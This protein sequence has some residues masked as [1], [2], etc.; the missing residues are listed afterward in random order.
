MSDAAAPGDKN[1]K[2]MNGQAQKKI[3]RRDFLSGTVGLGLLFG[4]RVYAEEFA[5]GPAKAT[6]PNAPTV[7]CAV[8][9]L[10]EQGRAILTALGNASGVTVKYI[11]D[12]YENI[13]ARAQEIAPKAQAVADY[14]KI[15]DDKSVQAVWIAT[16]TH[17]HKDI[18]VAAL[19]AGK[20]VFCEAPL[21]STIEDARAIAKAAQ[22]AE[23]QIFHSGLQER[24][25]P[26]HKHVLQFIRTEALG[27]MTQARSHW[28]KRV[29]WRRQAP[30]DERQKA[31]NWR[32]SKET[33]TGLAGEIGVHHVDTAN[34]FLKAR[35][36]SVTGFGGVM[37][38]KDG[39]DVADTVQC[40]YQYPGGINYFFDATLSNS[41]DGT[42]QI[43]Q[44][45]EAAVMVR[46]QRAWMFKE[47]D[48][49]ALGWEVYA[50]KEKVAEDTGIALVADA[51]KILSAGKNPG[52]NRDVNPKETQLFHA[53]EAFLNS[54]RDGSGKKWRCGALEGFQATV[55]AIKANEAIVTGKKIDFQKEWFEI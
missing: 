9:G 52:E 31:L 14:K 3:D 15:L 6:N 40:I 24:T 17:L 5:P 23:K 47:A 28:H 46:D 2:K 53:C 32:L 49:R 33:S 55:C 27:E 42:A 20:H 18:A 25:N 29:S 35:P 50:Y 51:T 26:Q 19:Q 16:P 38:W 44:G 22:A 1:A 34:Y 43:F 36:L 37:A 8:I 7:V 10:G 48:A 41:Y 39:R 11:C 45:T 12:S 54:I 30:T 13:H 21:A 4:A